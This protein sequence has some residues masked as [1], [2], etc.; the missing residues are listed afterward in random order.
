[1]VW[2][3]LRNFARGYLILCGLIVVFII[4]SFIVSTLFHLAGARDLR[5]SEVNESHQISGDV[6]VP[7][8]IWRYELISLDHQLLNEHLRS[9]AGLTLWVKGRAYHAN[10]TRMDFENIDDGIDSYSGKF[11]GERESN[12]LLTTGPRTIIGSVTLHGETFTS[13]PALSGGRGGDDPSPP[14]FIYDTRDVFPVPILIHG[15]W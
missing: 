4:G 13:E 1:M 9:G 14:H 2:E 11:D 7:F 8:P 3:G 5:F 12:L 10:L 15:I 6:K